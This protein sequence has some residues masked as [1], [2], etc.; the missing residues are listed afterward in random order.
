[1][2]RY[3]KAKESLAK[4]PEFV[5]VGFHIGRF[6]MAVVDTKKDRT[7]MDGLYN[8]LESASTQ[9]NVSISYL[10]FYN[11]FCMILT[12]PPSTMQDLVEHSSSKDQFLI[13][14]IKRLTETQTFEDELK[15]VS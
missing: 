4:D 5:K 13:V 14:A 11:L 12:P 15:E 10:M 1:V 2:W 9:L 7:N 3:S 6:I 8:D